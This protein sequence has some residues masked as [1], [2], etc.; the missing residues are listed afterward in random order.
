MIAAMSSNMTSVVPLYWTLV[1]VICFPC[2]V[3]SSTLRGKPATVICWLELISS[4]WVGW[5]EERERGHQVIV[6]PDS[7]RSGPPVGHEGHTG[8]E[9]IVGHD[10]AVGVMGRRGA[11]VVKDVGQ[12]GVGRSRGFIRWIA[13]LL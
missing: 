1:S 3:V 5:A 8:G 10:P 13:M 11:V 2:S 12:Q 6:W 7:L 9:D 4:L